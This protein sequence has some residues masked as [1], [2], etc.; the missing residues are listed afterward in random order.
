MS[1]IQPL[2]SVLTTLFRNFSR[3]LVPFEVKYDL[4][5]GLIYLNL[6]VRNKCFSTKDIVTL[7]LIPQLSYASPDRLKRT[8]D[9]LLRMRRIIEL[10]NR[11]VDAC[12][13]DN[14]TRIAMVD[15]LDP[16][17]IILTDSITY[18]RDCTSGS[19]L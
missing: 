6:K 10:F 15:F 13:E 18:L 1:K 2:P 4:V 17:T 11:C 12:D 5:W 7:I 19:S 8:A 14:E 3:L 9:L 16:I